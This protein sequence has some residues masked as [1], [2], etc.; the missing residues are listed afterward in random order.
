M[1]RTYVFTSYE[2]YPINAGGC[3]VFIYNAMHQLLK[4][5]DNR[6]VLLLDM[7]KHECEL[8]TKDFQP[9]LPNSDNLRI[10]CL[11]EWIQD[12][13]YGEKFSNVFLQKS[14]RF[15]RGLNKLSLLQQIDYIEFFDYVGIGYFSVKAKRFEGLF[16][17][18]VLAARAHC[19]ID[20][21][22]LE[23]VPNS[24]DLNK[25]QMYQM[26]KEVMQDADV[27]LVPSNSWGE[28]YIQRYA[29]NPERVVVSPPPVELWDDVK[30]NTYENQ[31]NVIF[32]GRIFQLKGVDLFVD[33]AIALMIKRPENDSVFYLIGYDGL[34]LNGKP[35]KE[36]LLLR[37]P[38]HLKH[39][40]VFTGQL[41]HKELEQLLVN[42]RFAVFPNYVESFC[43]SIHELYNV[44]VP[45]IAN[46]IP[47]FRDYFNH[48]KNALLYHGTSSD[49]VKQMECLLDNDEIRHR[50][51]I[52]YRVINN[53]EFNVI[54][55][56]LFAFN[57][58]ADKVKVLEESKLSIIILDEG[59]ISEQR[60][61]SLMTH[62]RV[63]KDKSYILKNNSYGTPVHYLG[64][65]R[66]ASKIDGNSDDLLPVNKYILTCYA[67]DFIDTEYITAS[68]DILDANDSVQYVGAQYKNTDHYEQYSL[69][70]PNTYSDY[71][72]LTRAVFRLDEFSKS[73]RDIYDIRLK[74]LGEKRF[75][76]MTGYI[77]PKEYITQGEAGILNVKEEQYIY[78]T[79][80]STRNNEWNPYVLYP[81]LIHS[82]SSIYS[83]M[84]QQNHDAA[85]KIYQRLKY[86]VDAVSGRR[87]KMLVKVLERLHREFKRRF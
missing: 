87:G 31:K 3:G 72:R 58:P 70:E 66:Y 74:E 52:P 21:M 61:I 23:Q 13:A 68:L 48:Q 34:D 47:A 85:R 27:L 7:P 56:G 39:R 86:K 43:Y 25:L 17:K 54:Y 49:L 6:V 51:S 4:N 11:S 59:E 30:Y 5:S 69:L 71:N 83:N 55:E 73:L 57:Q 64:K 80:Y 82:N 12:E 36:Q 40:F 65:L 28:I 79:H 2:L 1:V 45:I 50:I 33:A 67:N 44:G 10:I 35:Y 42:V 41:N 8:F 18:T 32:Y 60:S 76:R 84:G 19:T 63:D 37:I 81:Y 20:L 77:L 29:V 75:L 62:P 9:S 46:D 78:S 15:F 24:F 26:E 22:D 14:Y 16:S 38:N 53:Q